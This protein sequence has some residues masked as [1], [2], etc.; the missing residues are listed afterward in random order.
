M[1]NSISRLDTLC[2]GL[3]GITSLPEAEMRFGIQPSGTEQYN[4]HC[5]FN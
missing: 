3:T 2:D 1:D 4:I 5:V